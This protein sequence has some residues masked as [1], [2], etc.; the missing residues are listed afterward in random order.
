MKK[1][2]RIALIILL[3]LFLYGCNISKY[4]KIEKPSN[5]YYTKNLLSLV[6][7]EKC[8][9]QILDT[10]VYHEEIVMKE[11]IPVI[12]DMI[13]S[14]QSENFLKEVPEDLPKTPLYKLFIESE[15]NK[16]IIDVYGSDII[17]I[18]PWD[19]DFEKDYITLDNIPNAYKMEQ[20]CKYVLE[21]Q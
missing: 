3:T 1:A 12:H 2:I 5:Y 6:N 18:Y 4:I 21:K 19:G 7:N 15:G 14:L 10:N 17:T 9:V 20:F 8:D 13:K 11:D 16:M